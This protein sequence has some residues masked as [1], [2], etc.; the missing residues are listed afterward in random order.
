MVSSSSA[1]SKVPASAKSWLWKLVLPVVLVALAVAGGLYYRSRLSRQLTDKDTIVLSDFTNTTGDPVF[2]DTLK[3][4][5]SVQLGQS[6]FLLLI[7]DRK[8][9]EI[10]KQMG[11]PA[12]DRL[13]PEVAR[14]V[15]LRTGSKAML[16]GSIASLGSQYV[17]GL[18]A[19]NCDTG[20]LLAEAQEQAAGKEGVLKALDRAAVSLR[21]KLGESLSSVHQFDAPLEGATTSSL[22]ALKAYSLAQKT[23]WAK[24]DNA[25]LPLYKQA[26]ELDPNFAGAYNSLAVAYSNLNQEGR[27]AENAR[28]AYELREK[29]TDRE[30]FS[31]EAFY[32]EFATGDLEKTAQVYQL[33]QQTYPRDYATYVDLALISSNLGR[34]DKALEQD[35]QAMSMDSSHVNRYANLGTDY[36]ALNRL[37]EAEAVYKRA[38]ERKLEGQILAQ[39]R[40]Q[41]AFLK[42]DTAL[43]AQL[44]ADSMGTAG[45][46]DVML[47]SQADTEAWNG[48]LTSARELTRRAMDS[49][50]HNDAPETAA[51]Y[52]MVAALRE[53]ESGNR[54]QA[55]ADANAAVKLGPN[56]D[57]RALAALALARAGD[58]AAAEKLA[59]ELDK[60]VPQDTLVQQYWLPT[61]R[62]AVALER[63]DAKRAIALLEMARPIELGEPLNMVPVLFPPYVRGQAYL[64]LH[65][66]HAAAAEF[67]KLIDHYGLV[68]NFYF[69]ATARLG[70][71]RAYAL[72][73]AKD[74]AARDKARAAYRDFLTLWTAADPDV[75]ILRQA[76]AEYARLE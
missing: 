24:G 62:A 76:K 8:V 38:Q 43:M 59:E 51:G 41:L 69:G 35:L 12:G 32:Y 30:R 6:P 10:L 9:N 72:D 45:A 74:P 23:R 39:G 14:E 46:E 54:E 47:A 31:I 66:G 75:P 42:G 68:G 18:K 22:D 37:D 33:W 17:V 53:V 15:C 60:E 58:T 67:Q 57:V 28:K 27:A 25:S 4:G 70:L 26:V 1:S 5:L 20:D 44:V 52:Q 36:L 65:D 61:I 34:W 64:M 55:R 63:N 13:T 73:A 56:R 29:V 48:K 50:Q 49:A 3:Q 21:P 2:D 19:V 7:S 40:Y 71:A 11:R 16:A